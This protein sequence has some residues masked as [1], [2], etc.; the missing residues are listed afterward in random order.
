MSAL[1]HVSSTL[2]HSYCHQQMPH[3]TTAVFGAVAALFFTDMRVSA[4]A[5]H[6]QHVY[7]TADEVCTATTFSGTACTATATASTAIVAALHG[8]SQH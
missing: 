2:P 8:Y 6:L 4:A 3:E 1:Q 7:R 5:I